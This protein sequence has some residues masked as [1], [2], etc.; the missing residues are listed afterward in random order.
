MSEALKARWANIYS[1]FRSGEGKSRS[2]WAY[3]RLG[4]FEATPLAA[5]T[6]ALYA[7]LYLVGGP[8]FRV[9]LVYH[10]DGLFVA[11][12]IKN[13]QTDG[14]YYLSTLIGAPY[15]QNLLDY[16]VGGER[17]QLFTVK[18]LGR[19]ENDPFV[20]ANVYF[21]L[22]FV[23]V[24]L[25]SHFVA[26]KLG[27]RP[28]TAGVVSLLY[29]FL[30]FHI[31]HGPSHLFLS[32][33]YVVPLG[34][35]L[36]VWYLEDG[37]PILETEKS[38]FSSRERLVR[39][40]S[41]AFIVLIVGSTSAYY[42][43]FVVLLLVGVC[44]LDYL[45]NVDWRRLASAV[46]LVA[47]IGLTLVANVL[48]ELLYRFEH[49]KNPLVAVRDAFESGLYGLRLTLLIVPHVLHQ[50]EILGKLGEH[51][52]K[53]IPGGE[54]GS[55]LGALGALGFVLSAGLALAPKPKLGSTW[56]PPLVQRLGFINV[57]A[58]LIGTVGGVG[59]FIA[60]LGFTQIRAWG[61]IAVL[62][63]F[64]S[65]V[66]L[67]ALA[68]K[69]FGR[70]WDSPKGRIATLAMV[71][72]LVPAAI[73][74]QVPR[75]HRGELATIPAEKRS[76]QDFISKMESELPSGS[77]VFQL[78]AIPFPEFG[79]VVNLRDYDLLRGYLLGTGSLRWSYGALKGRASGDW[80]QALAKQPPAVMVD[81]LAA[82]GFSA[83][84]VD[85]RGFEDRG[86]TLDSEL[87]PLVG[88][89]AGQSANGNLRFYD[90]RAVRERLVE[91]MG[92]SGVEALGDRVTH[93]LLD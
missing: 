6:L 74:D 43:I 60:V 72:L 17:F 88:P 8:G 28:L 35:L 46:V 78:P 75:N 42:A 13:M 57:L 55:Y 47:C 70:R 83:I 21:A 10:R 63:G 84:Y 23:F 38:A 93:R 3:G 67:G 39:L 82:A 90:I 62:I 61:R 73:F 41:V 4:L 53:S 19:V 91:R 24:A 20:V 25:S 64:V 52:A 5:I 85:V 68:E 71:A 11:M 16:P 79:P 1:R 89:P 30:P 59:F 56:V 49:G 12:L 22:G 7:R 66:S 36:V 31:W 32:A 76:D 34:I 51:A 14:K 48:P 65:L 18:L 27:L 87:R 26:R 54:S 33:Y 86:A 81:G 77:L 58:S 69:W 40:L 15:G 80:Q 29:A 50:V 9:P 45:Q 37:I 2:V 92:E 44:V